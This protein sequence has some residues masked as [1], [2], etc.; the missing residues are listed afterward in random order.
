M[1]K[2]CPLG[3]IESHACWGCCFN[4]GNTCIYNEIVEERK[5]EEKRKAREAS[6]LKITIER[7]ED[8]EMKKFPYFWMISRG[9]AN[10]GHGWSATEAEA[11][12]FAYEYYKATEEVR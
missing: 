2:N 5:E 10:C 9:G 1:P 12:Q 8:E 3:K 6:Q 7:I 4:F 11:L